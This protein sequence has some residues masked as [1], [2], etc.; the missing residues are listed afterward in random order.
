MVSA[1]FNR[2]NIKITASIVPVAFGLS[3]M[4]WSLWRHIGGPQSVLLEALLMVVCV[5]ISHHARL[6]CEG[7]TGRW[8]VIPFVERGL[9]LVVP[10]AIVT[11]RRSDFAV[12]NVAL[13]AVTVEIGKR[14]K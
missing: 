12:V 2:R 11:R 10:R 9:W 1:A 3:L 8:P 4:F 5:L 7:K 13:P 6:V 14:T